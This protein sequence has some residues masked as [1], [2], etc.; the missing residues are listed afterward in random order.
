MKID[1]VCYDAIVDDDLRY[2]ATIPGKL[3]FMN[4]D[5][6]T[7]DGLQYFANRTGDLHFYNSVKIT[8]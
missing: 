5:K 4:C 8:N 1:V 2:I 6:I 7:D 3:T